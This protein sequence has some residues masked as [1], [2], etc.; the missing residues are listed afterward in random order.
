MNQNTMKSCDIVSHFKELCCNMC[1]SLL[2]GFTIVFISLIILE[3]GV[4][5]KLK[6]FI[7]MM[8]QKSGTNNWPPSMF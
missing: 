6:D 5:K 7:E 2:I 3:Q 1:I 4:K 8:Y